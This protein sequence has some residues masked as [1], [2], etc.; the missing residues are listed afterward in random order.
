MLEES[1][2]QI[3]SLLEE[4]ARRERPTCCNHE[5]A[6]VLK[7]ERGLVFPYL[8]LLKIALEYSRF[9]TL[10]NI[11]GWISNEILLYS[12]GNCI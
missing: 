4:G 3:W 5:L 1:G 12:T 10:Y 8:F 7:L 2:S 6:L 9:T 11:F